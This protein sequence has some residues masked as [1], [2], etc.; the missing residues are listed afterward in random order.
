[1]K[2]RLYEI[3]VQQPEL[4]LG[5]IEHLYAEVAG[6]ELRE[7]QVLREDF[8]GTANLAAMWVRSRAHRRAIGVD[9]DAKIIRYAER[10]NRRPLREAASRLKLV[11]ADVLQCHA[12]AD[13]L[14]SLNFSHFIYKTR[15]ELLRYFRHARRCLRPGGL[16][17]CDAYGGP[18]ALRLC[19]DERRFGDFTYLWEQA[20]Y[21]PITAAVVN[22]I[23]FRFPD[24]SKLERAFTYRWR[25]WTLPELHELL[26][27]AGFANPRTC[28]EVDDGFAEAIDTSDLDAWVAYLAARPLPRP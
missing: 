20:S 25:L 2:H 18:G 24:G 4:M 28:F 22:H 19:T 14:V 7:P 6:G 21:D 8:C 10:R 27:E 23:H 17:V 5:L 16:L 13:A 15:A 11:H 1:M 12:R 3:A 9:R 26:A